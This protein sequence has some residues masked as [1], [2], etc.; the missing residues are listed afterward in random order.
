MMRVLLPLAAQAQWGALAH[1][2]Q[3]A[4]DRYGITALFRRQARNGPVVLGIAKD[5]ALEKSDQRAF[6]F[7][8]NF[9]VIVVHAAGFTS[10]GRRRRRSCAH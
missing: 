4:D 2:D 6:F 5:D 1:V 3:R 9:S 7:A 8:A 10:T